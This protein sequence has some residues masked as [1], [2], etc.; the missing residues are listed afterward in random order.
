MEDGLYIKEIA[1]RLG[2]DIDGDATLFIKGISTL[3]EA[4]EGEISFLTSPKYKKEL[5]TTKASAVIVDK[6]ISLKGRPNL[7]LLKVDNAN[8]AFA[9][10][11][12][13]FHKKEHTPIGISSEAN[14]QEDVFLGEDVSVYPGVFISKG[15]HIGHRVTLMPGT[16]IGEKVV[17]GD[18]T[19]IYPNVTI[20]ERC[21]IGK[22]V[23]I[24]PGVVI[25][26]DGFRFVP[27]GKKHFKVPQVGIVEVGDD[28][29]IGANCCI[30][31]ATLGRTL[32]R[33]GV[34]MDNLIQVGHNVEIGA[35]SI[36]VAQVGISGSTVIGENVLLAGQVGIVGHVKIGDGVMVG[37]K[38]GVA[39]DIPPGEI[40]SGTP[41]VPHRIWLKLTRLIPRLPEFF[42]RLRDLET[43]LKQ[44]E[45]K[46]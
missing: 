5:E 7:T 45:D 34:K 1:R 8:L 15:A 23:I 12:T 38:S 43:R 46:K 36:I 19:I 35:N 27:E 9:K 3:K 21:R 17:I 4:R 44:I 33:D 14:I 20:L 31:R 13:L 26:S 37:G 29:E 18:D 6:K 42:K 32:I 10:V 22:R 24:H 41:A 11:L 2:G 25:G 30:D 40:V 16:F 39:K 28:V